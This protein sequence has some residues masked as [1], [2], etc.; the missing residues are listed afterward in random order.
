[1]RL[2]EETAACQA[3]R[4][5]AQ[6]APAAVGHGL[7]CA[8]LL[9]ESDADLVHRCRKGD[10]AAFAALVKRHQ[11]AVY[12]HLR[13]MA[14]DWNTT[15]DLTQEV[16]IRAWKRINDLRNPRAFRSWLNHIATNLFYDELRKRPKNLSTVSMDEPISTD[17]LDENF[18]RD[19][20]DT[21]AL[22]D[23]CFQRKELAEAI[24]QAMAQL[25]ELFRKTIVLRELEG[26]SYQ[27]IAQLTGSEMGT[28]KSRIARARLRIQHSIAPYLLAS[29]LQPGRSDIQCHAGRHP[30]KVLPLS[31]N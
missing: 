8:R 16:F 23:E 9:A 26:L 3:L 22:P 4:A 17:D 6:L 15:A 2:P 30:L 18:T 13:Q 1:M 24:R 27:D 12:N 29:D 25:P 19:I 5:S 28:V 14:P 10:H 31:C 11:L 20:A 7:A 21:S